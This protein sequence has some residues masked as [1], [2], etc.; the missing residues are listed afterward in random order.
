M[1][2]LNNDDNPNFKYRYKIKRIILTGFL[3]HTWMSESKQ[4]VCTVWINLSPADTIGAGRR[5]PNTGVAK[6]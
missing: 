4:Y 6:Y 1:L 3:W 2:T 5:V